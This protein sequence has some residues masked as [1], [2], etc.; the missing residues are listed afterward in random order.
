ML[1]EQAKKELEDWYKR[2]ED[3]ISKTKT[4]NRYAI[5]LKSH[6]LITYI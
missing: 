4:A 5:M 3:T 2:H 1:R 6:I